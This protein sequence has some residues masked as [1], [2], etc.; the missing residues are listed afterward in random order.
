MQDKSWQCLSGIP[1][2]DAGPGD[3]KECEGW[4]YDRTVLCRGLRSRS[5]HFLSGAVNN[6]FFQ[7]R[8]PL[9]ISQKVTYLQNYISRFLSTAVNRASEANLLISHSLIRSFVQIAQ[10]AQH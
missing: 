5:L 8:Q 9:L 10:I 4:T 1:E 7:I 6:L 3:I 2:E